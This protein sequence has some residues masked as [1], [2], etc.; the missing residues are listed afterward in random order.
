MTWITF[1]IVSLGGDPIGDVTLSD[2][3]GGF[4][5]RPMVLV[6]TFEPITIRQ[7]R[8][9]IFSALGAASPSQITPIAF[10]AMATI[11]STIA[12]SGVE[13]RPW[14]TAGLA[15]NNQPTT[16]AEYAVELRLPP[17]R[18]LVGLTV[19]HPLRVSGS[20][21][22]EGLPA[23]YERPGETPRTELIG[24]RWA[25]AVM[26]DEQ[27]GDFNRDGKIDGVDLATW[28]AGYGETY[29]GR[30]LLDWQ[31]QGGVDFSAPLSIV[32]E[33]ATWMLL[34]IACC[35]AGV[36]RRGRRRCRLR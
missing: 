32:V 6:E 23:W 5:G 36:S 15:G 14:G 18:H 3:T 29:S 16:L 4:S 20:R 9:V 22:A 17:G 35:W 12:V 19:P 10:V 24:R 25:L 11:P 30:E 8:A 7:I 31:R 26:V 2:H 28:S 33:P 21:S 27:A 1:L 34:V 13:S